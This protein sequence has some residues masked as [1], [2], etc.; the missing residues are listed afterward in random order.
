MAVDEK[1]FLFSIQIH[2]SSH[3]CLYKVHHEIDL[4]DIN[5]S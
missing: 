2:E 5:V 4:E 3:K 1:G